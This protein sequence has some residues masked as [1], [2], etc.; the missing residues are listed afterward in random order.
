MQEQ[1]LGD[2]SSSEEKREYIRNRIRMAKELVALRGL[3]KTP[4]DHEYVREL[5]VEFS[6]VEAILQLLGEE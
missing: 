5:F 3:C 4:E 2:F 1:K 6:R